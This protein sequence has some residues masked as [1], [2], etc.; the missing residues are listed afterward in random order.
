MVMDIIADI[1][2]DTKGDMGKCQHGTST[3][4]AD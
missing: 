1:S 4:T 3:S 2:K